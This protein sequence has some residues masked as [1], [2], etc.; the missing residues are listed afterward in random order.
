MPLGQIY[1]RGTGERLE[2]AMDISIGTQMRFA[3]ELAV[4]KRGDEFQYRRIPTLETWHDARR[5]RAE[6]LTRDM[7]RRKGKGAITAE[8][9]FNRVQ[10]CG[11]ACAYCRLPLIEIMTVDYIGIVKRQRI[12]WETG[13]I[14]WT[15]DH[16][17]PIA[18][19]GTDFLANLFPCCGTCNSSKGH[20]SAPIATT[21][22]KVRWYED[23]PWKTMKS[24]HYQDIPEPAEALAGVML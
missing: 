1:G 21:T 8:G 7:R 23:L 16:R 6:R 18:R 22:A 4:L 9:I 24:N 15:V 19:G 5:K 3:R 2:T 12:Y 10:F 20:R 17:I 13:F 11:F 14:E